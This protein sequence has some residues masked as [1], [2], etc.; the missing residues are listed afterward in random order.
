MKTLRNVLFVLICGLGL[1]AARVASAGQTSG[2]YTC[3]WW[4]ETCDDA[5]FGEVGQVRCVGAP[6][7]SDCSLA[8]ENCT[9][10][11]PG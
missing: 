1:V 6:G 2:C 7:W 5:D 8:G 4:Y 10:G 9:P 3:H 11:E